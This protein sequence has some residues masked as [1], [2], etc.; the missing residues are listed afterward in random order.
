MRVTSAK[1]L[2]KAHRLLAERKVRIV[3][4][5]PYGCTANV[6]GDTG[7]YEVTL[8]RGEYTCTCA[9][10]EYRPSWICS[11]AAAVSLIYDTIKSAEPFDAPNV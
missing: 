1:Q 10:S 9:L 8:F 4:F 7:A 2:E 5:G 6:R 3:A 11:H